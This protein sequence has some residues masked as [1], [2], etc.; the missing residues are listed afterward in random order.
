MFIY[1]NQKLL[2]LCVKNHLLNHLHKNPNLTALPYCR[3]VNVSEYGLAAACD[4]GT[5]FGQAPQMA[6]KI[7]LSH[8]CVCIFAVRN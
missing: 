3:K 2:F 7:R 8:M 4:C 6:H 5:P 1:E